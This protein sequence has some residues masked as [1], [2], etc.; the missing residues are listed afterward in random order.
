MDH[1]GEVGILVVQPAVLPGDLLADGPVGVRVAG[2]DGEQGAVVVRRH[3]AGASVH[4][5]AEVGGGLA[6][7]LQEG[8]LPATAV[9]VTDPL[10]AHALELAQVKRRAG[11]PGGA[12]GRFAG[13]L[14]LPQRFLGL[15]EV[16]GG[17]PALGPRHGRSSLPGQGLPRPPLHQAAAVR[18]EGQAARRRTGALR[19]P[20][21]RQQFGASVGVP[22]FHPIPIPVG[23]CSQPTP[24]RAPGGALDRKAGRQAVPLPAARRVPQRQPA[25]MPDEQ[26][27]AVRRP[28]RPLRLVR[29][30]EPVSFA[31]GRRVQQQDFAL[32]PLAFHGL[33]QRHA[34]PVRTDDRTAL[35]GRDRPH[36]VPRGIVVGGHA[37]WPGHDECGPE[38][39]LPGVGLVRQRQCHGEQFAPGEV[40][41]LH[42]RRLN[43]TPFRDGP[44]E[45]MD[46]IALV[47]RDRQ[48][49]GVSAEGELPHSMLA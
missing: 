27:P 45:G 19:Q 11:T 25:S 24:L 17:G 8:V 6:P 9:V 3:V 13:A 31:A 42:P 30:G 38:Y 32:P 7:L 28:G 40:K 35:P 23:G 26:R 22:Q 21:Q 36:L 47:G 5:A 37:P 48:R 4:G 34:G 49:A 16:P 43:V 33:Q 1:E 29:Q 44:H 20:T 10:E 41:H 2:M 46:R 12:G 18:A 39:D 15:V 14:F